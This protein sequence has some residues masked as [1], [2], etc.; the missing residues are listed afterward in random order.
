MNETD[1]LS[2]VVLIITLQALVKP[3]GLFTKKI[4]TGTVIREDLVLTA[5]HCFADVHRNNALPEIIRIRLGF[6]YGVARDRYVGIQPSDV[7]INPSY[8]YKIKND[9]AI[10]RSRRKLL[11]RKSQVV[12]LPA[13]PFADDKKC[14]IAGFGEKQAQDKMASITLSQ[15]PIDLTNVNRC[16]YRLLFKILGIHVECLRFYDTGPCLGDSGGPLICDHTLYGV[17]SR[18]FVKN[19][20][21]TGDSVVL[22]EDIFAN[23]E[24]I[25]TVMNST[26]I[27]YSSSDTMR[28]AIAVLLCLLLLTNTL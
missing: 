20:C 28:S 16:P 8:S 19:V 11:Y 4:C 12:A 21:D 27:S 15:M 22:Y 9:L 13:D 24:W 3:S 23:M 25:S 2:S 14:L 17:L 1:N 26:P 18:G 6:G 7:H 5:A 10:L